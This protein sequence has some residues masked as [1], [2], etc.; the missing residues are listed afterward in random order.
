MAITKVV[1]VTQYIEV[2]IDETKFDA[3]FFEQFNATIFDAGEELDEHFK[4][5]AQLNARGIYDNEDFI[6]GYGPAEDMG[7]K[8]KARDN[9]F[10]VDIDGYLTRQLAEG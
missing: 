8:F 4:H 1:S 9:D 2:T 7:I 6:E 5:L 10:E 3:D